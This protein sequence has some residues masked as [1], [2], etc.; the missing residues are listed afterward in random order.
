MVE[1]GQRNHASW[2]DGT[3]WNRL[4]DY[5]SNWDDLSL[6]EKER[7]REGAGSTF[8]SARRPSAALREAGDVDSLYNDGAETSPGFGEDKRW[9]ICGECTGTGR[10]STR[11]R[12]AIQPHRQPTSPH[13]LMP[14]QMT[15]SSSNTSN[16]RNTPS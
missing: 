5:P 7:W 3:R 4:A 2:A 14:S 12:T 11:L 9:S 13:P 6:D 15:S 1:A 8:S 16:T 10:I